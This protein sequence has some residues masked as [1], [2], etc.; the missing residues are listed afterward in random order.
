MYIFKKKKTL[1]LPPGTAK[2]PPAGTAKR[3]APGKKRSV[4]C[5]TS[6]CAKEPPTTSKR[7]R[8]HTAEVREAAAILVHAK[9]QHTA[10]IH[11][12]IEGVDRETTSPPDI[13]HALL[14]NNNGVL[15]F[16]FAIAA[17]MSKYTVPLTSVQA[18]QATA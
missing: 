10:M 3:S 5:L 7:A 9:E 17:L 18:P 12:D 15:T 2:K 1:K 8:K 14:E 16:G 4:A 6:K 11:V 13:K